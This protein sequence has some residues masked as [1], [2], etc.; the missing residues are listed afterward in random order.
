MNKRNA[1]G[2]FGAAVICL[3]TVGVITVGFVK[4]QNW[5]SRN[6]SGEMALAAGDLPEAR[7][8]LVAALAVAGAFSPHD[9]R[10]IRTIGNLAETE[11]QL[12]DLE[13]AEPLFLRWLEALEQAGDRQ[14]DQLTAALDGLLFGY[15]QQHRF[16]DAEELAR[17]A[18]RIAETKHGTDSPGIA[19]RLVQLGDLVRAQDRAESATPI[20]QRAAEIARHHAS[21]GKALN[22]SL[23]RLAAIDRAHGRYASAQRFLEQALAA[24]DARPAPEIPSLVRILTELSIIHR[25]QGNTQAA[26]QFGKR[27]LSLV[28]ANLGPNHYLAAAPLDQLAHGYRQAGRVA[29]AERYYQRSL[30]IRRAASRQQ[31]AAAAATLSGLANLYQARGEPQDAEAYFHRALR[32]IGAALG[33]NHPDVA[34]SL[35]DLAA[36]YAAQGRLVD[37]EP[38]YERSVRIFEKAFGARHPQVANA[39]DDHAVFLRRINRNTAAEAANARAD[40]IRAGTID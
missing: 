30:A 6:S 13:A 34:A 24:L 9:P 10:L 37:A 35:H 18:I 11:R 14:S 15:E 29:E 3:M 7:T 23:S 27:A 39:L 1:V 26:R 16:A 21:A 38:L 32:V 31:E 12:G 40:A 22:D 19:T 4:I 25:H 33:P 36:H 20:Y 5:D 8:Q 28:E 17:R 2:I